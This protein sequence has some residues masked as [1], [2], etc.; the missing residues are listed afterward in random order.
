M[1]IPVSFN[2]QIYETY[3]TAKQ[4]PN[5]KSQPENLEV[6]LEFGKIEHELLFFLFSAYSL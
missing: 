6:M 4:K 1:N 5:M 2:I 3:N